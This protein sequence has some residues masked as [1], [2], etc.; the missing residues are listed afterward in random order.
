MQTAQH[1]NTQV[2]RVQPARA[3]TT[4]QA[5]IDLWGFLEFY[6]PSVVVLSLLVVGC[7]GGIAAYF[8]ISMP[9]WVL[10][11]C[12]VGA[13]STLSAAI[14]MAHTKWIMGLLTAAVLFDLVVIITG[15]IIS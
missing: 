12:V 10:G 11:T 14:G 9:L 1:V 7:L 8:A 3:K 13:T 2:P 6:R 5:R 15:M 4:P